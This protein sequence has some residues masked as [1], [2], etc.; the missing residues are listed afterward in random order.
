MKEDR[1]SEDEDNVAGAKS[2][3]FKGANYEKNKNKNKNRGSQAKKEGRENSIPAEFEIDKGDNDTDEESNDPA[4]D[5]I[6]SDMDYFMSE[7]RMLWVN[8]MLKEGDTWSKVLRIS[9]MDIDPDRIEINSL[10]LP[11]KF[12]NHRG[13]CICGTRHKARD[14]GMHSSQAPHPSRMVDTW[15]LERANEG[16]SLE[17]LRARMVAQFIE[18]QHGFENQPTKLSK[19]GRTSQTWTRKA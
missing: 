18:E 6:V 12:G 10:R 8:M 3:G 17:E 15:V 13:L 1:V 9:E 4:C 7:E 11:M 16:E 5:E 19:R 14:S 2:L